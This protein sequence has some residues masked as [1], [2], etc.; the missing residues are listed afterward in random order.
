MSL[1][2]V[3]A[4]KLYNIHSAQYV[5]ITVFSV[6]SIT[7]VFVIT[8]LNQRLEINEGKLHVFHHQHGHV[9]Q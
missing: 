3:I 6:M 5:I 4:F 2:N 8:K 9:R 1:E 7:Q